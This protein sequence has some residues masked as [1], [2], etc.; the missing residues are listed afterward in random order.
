MNATAL[1]AVVCMAFTAC[2]PLPPKIAEGE[3]ELRVRTSNWAH[4][5]DPL[6]GYQMPRTSWAPMEGVACTLSNDKGTWTVV[7]PG[8]VAV[9]RSTEPLTVQCTKE[10]YRPAR[11][12]LPCG[13][14][15]EMSRSA[16]KYAAAVSLVL[17]PLAIAAAPV[18]P[19]AA[20]QAAGQVL[21]V[22]VGA[23]AT[24]LT[25]GKTPDVCNYRDIEIFLSR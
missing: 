4:D 17:I 12:S 7:T 25:E 19:A 11:L 5:V 9:T 23:A 22:G 18:A 1:W 16:D 8:R 24:H 10:G 6:T 21:V 2:A 3:Q 14:P 13:T 15:H 20:A